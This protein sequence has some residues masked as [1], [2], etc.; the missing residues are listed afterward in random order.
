MEGDAEKGKV[1]LPY[2]PIAKDTVV[3]QGG[4]GNAA[5]LGCET[6]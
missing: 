6:R 5:E 1:Q 2:T 3:L 4:E